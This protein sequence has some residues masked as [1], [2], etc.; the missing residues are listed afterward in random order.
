MHGRATRRRHVRGGRDRVG[1]LRQC[2]GG[3]AKRE[4]FELREI[5]RLG[6]DAG[7]VQGRRA[8]GQ[9]QGGQCGEERSADARET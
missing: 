8:N 6:A 5:T 2:G 7:R 9:T 3:I 1:E 4:R